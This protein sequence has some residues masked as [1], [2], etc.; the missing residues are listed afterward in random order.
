MT[1]KNLTANANTLDG[2]RIEGGSDNAAIENVTAIGNGRFGIY[3]IIL[4]DHLTG[5]TV[6]LNHSTGID[7][8]QPGAVRVENNTVSFN[9][10]SGISV[11]NTVSGV[12]VVGN[13]DL[14][15]GKGNI[16]TGNAGYGIVGNGNGRLALAPC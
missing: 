3:V 11:T 7:L 14:T 15:L 8:E 5:S 4:I 6:T 12:A 9:L 13:A 10:G 2:I 1:V 16:V